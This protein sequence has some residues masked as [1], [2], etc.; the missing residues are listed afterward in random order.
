MTNT[1][2]TLAPYPGATATYGMMAAA[3]GD[4]IY[5]FFQLKTYEYSIT[6]NTWTL[7]APIP[8]SKAQGSAHLIDDKIYVVSTLSDYKLYAY[9]PIANQWTTE[10]NIPTSV[11]Y[12]EA[13]VS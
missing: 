10:V 12:T 6:N 2:Q 4:K 13:A 7:K 5:T 3:Y 11:H 9:D 1:W 8:T